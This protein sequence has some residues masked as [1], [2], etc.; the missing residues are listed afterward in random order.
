MRRSQVSFSG[1]VLDRIRGGGI[2]GGV[3]GGMP[4]VPGTAFGGATDPSSTR[5]G[6]G[7]RLIPSIQVSERYDS[8]VF[9]APKNQLRGLT[10][11]DFV[12]TI[13]PQVRALYATQEK[14]VKV[15]AVVGAV[16]GYYATNTGLSF[17]GANAGAT[18]DLSD[19]VS[20]WRPGTRLAVSDTY[21]YSPQPPAFLLGDQSGIQV[22][23]F[24]TG[25]QATRANTSS[26]SVNTIVELPLSGKVKLTGN[27]TNSFIHY[28]ASQ[29]QQATSLI[30][31]SVYTYTAGLLTQ[32]S[33]YDSLRVDFT[34]SEFDQ[35]QLGSFTT[36]G[37][38]VGWTHKFSPTLSVDTAGGVQLLS[39]ELNGVPFSPVIAPLGSLAI[40]WKNPT[41]SL[42]LAYR[43]GIAPSFQFQSVALL[44]HMV[45]C[46]I[47]Q[48]TPIDDVVSLFG[49]NY[50]V[51]NEYG[52]HSGGDLSWTTVGGTAGLL[53]RATQNTFL[54]LTYS[55]QNVD[56]IFRGTH[57]AYDRH[58]GQI[59]LAKAFY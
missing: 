58:V 48:N 30:S 34:A 46:N 14:L 39:G 53:Y 26:N 42:T 19:L 3:G 55:Y 15:N 51:A 56:N 11:E 21:F 38:T 41:T 18:L 8:N 59:A 27:Y 10:P 7:L 1:W 4:I 37:G 22:N 44:N 33:L 47:T 50:S 25:F 32:V 45:S 5:T 16:G 31:Q 9:F 23:P 29:V 52:S 40:L 43:T 13:V 36:R 57:F 49:A 54:T 28:G 17:V 20:R 12:T 24:I 6:N 2:G 35:G